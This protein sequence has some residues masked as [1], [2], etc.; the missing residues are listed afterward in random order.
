MDNISDLKFFVLLT[1][2]GSLSALARELGITPSAVS[3]RL[4][5][6]ER[7]LGVRLLNR[8]TRR[9][10][11]THE[12]ETYL[13]EGSR[14]LTELEELDQ[15]VSKSRATPRGLLRVNAT[16][17]FGRRHLA[18]AISEFVRKFPEIS[19]Q[20]QLSDRPANL[21][22]EGFDIG[23]VIGTPPDTRVMARRIAV[24]R[25]IL[26]ASPAYMRKHG[27]PANPHELTGHDCLVLRENAAAYGTWHL[28]RGGKEETV[29][30][31]GPLS[32]NDG[33]SVLTWALEGH[34]ILMRSEWDVRQY[35]ESGQLMQVLPEWSLPPADIHAIY[36][37]H[38]NISAKVSRF[39]EFLEAWFQDRIAPWHAPRK[40][41]PGTPR[42][43]RR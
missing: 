14:I 30:V 11:L 37:G 35:L 17:G 31:R 8:S 13:L 3:I 43:P 34:G 12:G 33:Q 25:R 40:I 6:L 5:R 1:Q 19:I 2:H 18:P 27:T 36:A 20:M 42:T 15:T 7:R 38:R 29:K 23:V 9:L 39:V 24:N 10:S 21:I 22:D 4:A 16:L 32:A 28:R 26:C 41:R